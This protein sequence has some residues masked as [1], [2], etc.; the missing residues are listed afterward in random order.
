MDTDEKIDTKRIGQIGPWIIFW[1]TRWRRPMIRTWRH[2]GWVG[3]DGAFQVGPFV[4]MRFP[5]QRGA[6]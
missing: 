2:E 4:G 1:T 3:C 6:E 5:K